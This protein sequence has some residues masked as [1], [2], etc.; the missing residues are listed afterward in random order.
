MKD[1][2]AAPY[3]T[4][5]EVRAVRE[6]PDRLTKERL[7][8]PQPLAASTLAASTLTS[9]VGGWRGWRCAR[10]SCLGLCL[11]LGFAGTR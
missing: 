9:G 6:Q 3:E 11:S 1:S 4:S 7:D 8:D 2:L 10:F 5:D